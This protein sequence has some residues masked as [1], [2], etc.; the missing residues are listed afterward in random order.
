MA[1]SPVTW[2]PQRRRRAAPKRSFL[3]RHQPKPWQIVLLVGFIILNE[4]RGLY[5]A[6]EVLKA[7]TAS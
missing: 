3:Q 6:V 7:W 4:M 1:P 5:V 2:M